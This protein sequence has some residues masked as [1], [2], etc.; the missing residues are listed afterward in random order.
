M[1]PLLRRPGVWLAIVL[2]GV[3][4]TGICAFILAF[5][6]CRFEVPP[7][8]ELVWTLSVSS[9]EL[10]A[11]G[12]AGP[13]RTSGHRLALL[14]IGPGPGDAAMIAGPEDGVPA[15]IDLVAFGVDGSSGRLDKDGRRQEGGALVAGF[16]FSL[17]PLPAGTEQEW[18]PE[19]VWAALPV[20]KRNVACT[21][22][23]TRSGVRPEFRCEFPTSVEWLDP[24]SGLYRQVRGLVATWR[25]DALRGVPLSAEIRFRIF[26]EQPLPAGRRGR[27]VILRLAWQGSSKAG[28]PVQLRSAAVAGAVVAGWV[29]ARR[30]PPAEALTRLRSGGKAFAGLAEGLLARLGSQ[31]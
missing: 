18:R 23:R 4:I 11:D 17:L 2:G 19:V 31:R 22:K 21:V 15:Q 9:A 27:E 16:D 14:G 1:P 25:F 28:D 29:A 6:P 10:A 7:G 26:D 12:S 30:A 13:P 3:L 8:R 24:A 20:G 5:Q